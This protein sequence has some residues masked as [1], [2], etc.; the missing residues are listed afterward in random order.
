MR[1]VVTPEEMRAIDAA[2][3]EDLDTLIGRAGWAN[4]VAARSL[5]GSVAGRRIVVLA[6]PGNNGAD[7]RVGA[8]ILERW[9][10]KVAVVDARTWRDASVVWSRC[11]LVIDAAF[12]TG[13]RRPFDAPDLAALCPRQ[14]LVL[15]VDI[16]SGLDGDTGAVLGSA[17]RAD[18]TVTFGAI[19][20]GLLFGRG[21]A[22]A[23]PVTV[24]DLG[25]DT[26][27]ARIHLLD[28]DD[29][30]SWPNRAVDAHKWQSA[31][32]VVGGQPSMPGAP[33][34]A[35]TAAARAGAGYVLA[36]FPASMPPPSIS[37]R[38]RRSKHRRRLGSGRH[39]PGRPGGGLRART[40]PYDRRPIRRTGQ[41]AGERR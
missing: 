38:G 8:Q 15:A 9:G 31:V 27:N 40:R 35:A 20:P 6:G 29:L 12:G 24:A 37:D 10:A 41:G 23:G 26:S 4:A 2:A 16:P 7:G 3:A 19:K 28:P 34:L 36:R 22:L 11:E 13:L 1:P 5:L 17:L 18:A 21:P 39:P 33:R 14:P 32:W 30:A 25:L